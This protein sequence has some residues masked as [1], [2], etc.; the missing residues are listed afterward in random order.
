MGD[1]AA[2]PFRVA[3]E[4]EPEY[5]E[6]RKGTTGI[7]G[8]AFEFK[9]CALAYL[10]AKEKWRKFKLASN[11]DGHGAFDDILIEYINSKSGLSHIFVQLKS[12]SERITLGKLTGNNKDFGLNKYYESYIDIEEKFNCTGGSVKIDSGIDERMFILY[13]N[14]DIGHGVKS[15]KDMDVG[16]AD[17]L[18][19]GGP[20][21]QFSKKKHKAIYEHLQNLP[22]YREFLRQFRIFYNQAD[23]EMM[24]SH[25]KPELQSIMN[26]YILD[27]VYTCFIDFMKDWWQKYN[28]FLK[29]NCKD[30]DP[31]LKTVKKVM[32]SVKNILDQRKSELDDL[33]IKYTESAIAD[34][35][36]LIKPYKAVLIFAPGRTTTLTAAKI[37]QTLGAT[38][39]IILNLH[40]FGSYRSEVTLAW[41][42]IVEVLVLEGGSSGE[43]FQDIFSEIS[44]ILNKTSAERKFIF[45]SNSIDNREQISA[46]QSLF[47]TNFTQKQ[48]IWKL[49]DITTQSM[50]II[51]EKNVTF[52]GT[53]IK[54]E[55]LVKENDLRRLNAL[56]CD[57]VS[58]LLGNKKPSIG[59]PIG[60]PPEYY[61]ARTLE[62]V[63]NIKCGIHTESELRSTGGW[64]PRTLL[65]G[66]EQI[67]LVTDEPGMGKSTLLTHLE[68]QTRKC[69]PD[70][71]IVRVNI[72]KYVSILQGI[73]TSGVVKEGAL[74]LLTKA[75]EIKETEGSQLE[76]QLFNHVYSCT[77]NMVVLI[78]GVDEVCP[79]YSEIVIEIL[80]TLSQGKIRKIWV[81]SRNSM[82]DQLEQEFQCQSYSLI[83]F[84]VSDQNSFLVK[85]WNQTNTNTTECVLENLAQQVVELSRNNLCSGHKDFMGVPFQSKLLARIFEKYIHETVLP[86]NVNYLHVCESYIN[87][88][89]DIYVVDKKDSHKANVSVRIDDDA[90]HEIFI[91]K[92]KAAALMA[93]LPTHHLEKI[94]D[95]KIKK[96]G[97]NF[98]QKIE[99]GLEKTGIIIDIIEKQPVFQSHI[100]AEYFVAVWLCD[101]VQ[102]SQT[103]MREHLLESR[104]DV[105]RGMVDRILAGKGT[106]HEAV[107]N[108]NMQ[109]VARRLKRKGTITHKDGGGRTPLHVAISCRNTGLIR[110]LLEHG[111][112]RSSVDTL[113]RYSPVEYATGMDDG[114]VL[115]LLME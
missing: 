82:K 27:L 74:R 12:T 64:R 15:N 69:H 3:N 21:L 32:T 10:R 89:W 80:R 20:V 39:H 76:E 86:Q 17:F 103:F 7:Q 85:F 109:D 51:L 67:I 36:K 78:D 14:A 9:L 83:P 61:I 13:S 111:A 43:D 42:N 84:S 55:H 1:Q 114:E 70:I 87:E 58:L 68:K 47:R 101:N 91:D 72:N 110:L 60:N 38:E 88:K 112:D 37:H 73:E 71:W 30:E 49:R 5:Y 48:E 59:N 34:M 63:T 57:S 105:V 44:D 23:E 95:M 92:H 77:R 97:A 96:M 79:D 106:I 19:T 90:L 62:K 46:F 33:R 99:Q 24:D 4:D 100:V 81:T 113:L 115:R 107:L 65:E 75:A 94:N 2:E 45:I 56:D 98:L 93:T 25:I 104:F 50:R 22:K 54:I 66:K 108:L 52:H 53:E 31:W 29:D 11:V 41:K 26:V 8:H 40:Q 35:E 28:Y 18:L 16:E 102:A 6:K